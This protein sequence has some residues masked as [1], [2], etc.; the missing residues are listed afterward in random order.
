MNKFENDKADGQG[1]GEITAKEI[2]ASKGSSGAVKEEE[3][4][5]AGKSQDSRRGRGEA[6]ADK[7]V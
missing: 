5:G 7:H 4:T 1:D 3:P 6:C 2:T